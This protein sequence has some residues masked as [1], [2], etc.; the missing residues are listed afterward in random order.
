MEKNESNKS[1]NVYSSDIS[2]AHDISNVMNADVTD[3]FVLQDTQILDSKDQTD[4]LMSI[5]LKEQEDL[6]KNIKRKST[7]KVYRGYQGKELSLLYQYDE[8]EEHSLKLSSIKNTAKSEPSISLLDT[9]SKEMRDTC[10]MDEM[11]QLLKITKRKQLRQR[12][13]DIPVKLHLDPIIDESDIEKNMQIILEQSR[14]KALKERETQLEIDESLEKG[15]GIIISDVSDFTDRIASVIAQKQLIQ[16]D[17]KSQPDV[18]IQIEKEESNQES[19]QDIEEK[20][21]PLVRNGVGSTLL[22][23]KQRGLIREPTKEEKSRAF[24]FDQHQRWLATRKLERLIESDNKKKTSKSIIDQDYNPQIELKY[25]DENGRLLDSKE[26]Y[27]ELSHQFH[28]KTSGKQK[29]EKKLKKLE[30]EKSIKIM[31]YTDTPLNTSLA[32]KEKQKSLGSAHVVISK[33]IIEQEES[34]IVNTVIKFP[35]IERANNS[36]SIISKPKIFGLKLRN[37]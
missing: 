35:T 9:R 20:A 31:S 29:T 33:G 1:I 37:K 21:E 27:K 28:G 10:S 7:S 34:N 30:Q 26:A 14:K 25:Y 32:L 2:I 11:N 17:I 19:I 3:I 4:V 6:S 18:E 23:L 8:I 12:A 36:H 22:L 5:Q 24:K 15:S 16:T 13:S